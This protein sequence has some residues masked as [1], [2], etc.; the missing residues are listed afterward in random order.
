MRRWTGAQAHKEFPGF[1]CV[2]A[3]SLDIIIV[4]YKE[5]L[6]PFYS[7]LLWFSLFLSWWSTSCLMSAAA[8]SSFVIEDS[9]L[10][11]RT[12]FEP[13]LMNRSFLGQTTAERLLLI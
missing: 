3:V 9:T 11:T 5:T 4:L 12:W 7:S 13:I 2:H 10:E 1:V 6:E 8:S